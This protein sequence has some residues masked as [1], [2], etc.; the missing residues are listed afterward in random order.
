MPYNGT[1]EQMKNRPIGVFDSGIGGLTVVQSLVKDMPHEDIVYFG[2]TARVPYGNKSPATIRRFTDE[3]MFFLKEKRV[4]TVVVACNTASSLA[5]E[6]MKKNS[7]FPVIGVVSSGTQEA[8]RLALNKKIGVIGTS[9]T[10]ESGAYSRELAK[11]GK[12]LK[13]YPKACP[14]FVPLVENC[15]IEDEITYMVAERYLMELKKKDVGV[16]ILGCTHYPVIKKV[17]QKV[18]GEVPLVDS[19]I[20]VS[21]HLSSVL[22]KKD[23]FSQRKRP[24]RIKCFVSDDVKGFSESCKLFLKKEITVKKALA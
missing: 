20:A 10:I 9:S 11:I 6:R 5:L 2:D 7:S 22:R 23:L 14:L 8:A 24:G 13:L 19:S 3:I 17:I 1:M 15:W 16:V 4:K 12:S 18:M 21:R